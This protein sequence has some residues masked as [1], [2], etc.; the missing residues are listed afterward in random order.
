M[1]NL[2][3]VILLVA[4]GEVFRRVATFEDALAAAQE[5]LTTQNAADT[6]APEAD[7]R[8]P[9]LIAS[10]PVVGSRI[11]ADQQRRRA[12]VAANAMFRD[13]ARQPGDNQVM[14]RSLDTVLKAYVSALDADPDAVD[15]AYN[16]ELVSRLR[17]A[18]VAGRAN[19]ITL[20]SESNMRGDKGAPPPETKPSEFNIIVPL[21]PEERQDQIDPRAGTVLRGKG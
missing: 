9:P 11:R 17:G 4:G 21:R 15:A 16:Y 14:V 18:L 3:V 6:L 10:L 8:I 12:L 2:V 7:A 1:K 20:R 13:L 5:Q 19:N